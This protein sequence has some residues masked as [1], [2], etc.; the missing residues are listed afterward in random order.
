MSSC[1]FGGIHRVFVGPFIRQ[2]SKIVTNSN[3]IMKQITDI[4]VVNFRFLG[5]LLNVVLY[6]LMGQ[7]ASVSCSSLALLWKNGNNCNCGH[8]LYFLSWNVI[9]MNMYNYCK[10]FRTV[11]DEVL[12]AM[13]GRF[14]FLGYA[15]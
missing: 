1:I 4:A 3:M 5:A 14:K 8:I 11:R 9:N 15:M 13:L 10:N 7:I 2:L 6:S 12:T